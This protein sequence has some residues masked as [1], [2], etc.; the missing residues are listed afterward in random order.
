MD[1]KINTILIF[2]CCLLIG[3]C[4]KNKEEQSSNT[5]PA[6]KKT[7]KKEEKLRPLKD[8]NV[9]EVLTLFGEDHAEDKVIIKTNFGDITIQLYENTPL[10]KANFLRLATYKY[11]DN[12]EFYRVI[13][14]F[15]VQGG[16][17]DELQHKGKKRK[18]GKY[19]IPAEFQPKNIHKKGAIAAAR[20]YENNPTKR[21]TPFDF[22]IVLGTVYN[23]L[24][25]DALAKENNVTFSPYQT[26][27]YTTIGG[28]ANLD[29]EHTVFGEVIEGMEIV[30]KIAQEEVS[31][32]DNWP[33]KDVSIISTEII[34]NQN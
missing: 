8:K 11:F 33:I 20:N 31:P 14:D 17:T 4:D 18:F 9:V 1:A 15:V 23:Q 22:Y 27:I 34:Q 7:K 10:H 26:E 12:T 32:E 2:F 25:L 13:K 30:I 16:D 5:G 3:S 6:T 24:Q 19:T 29:G 28:T 21:S